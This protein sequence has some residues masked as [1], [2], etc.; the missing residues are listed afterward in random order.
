MVTKP[1]RIMRDALLFLTALAASASAQTAGLLD[2]SFDPGIGPDGTIQALATQ[3]DGRILVAGLFSKWNG[4]PHR[5]LVRLNADGSLDASFSPQFSWP[6]NGGMFAIAV[7]P[8]GT[9]L[10]AGFL[11]SING[12]A[13]QG[14]VRLRP[15]G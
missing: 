4:Q 10:A 11:D 9:I 1:G 13:R 12:T 14:V 7:L 5:G 6:T 15:D 3:S 8:D 2:Q